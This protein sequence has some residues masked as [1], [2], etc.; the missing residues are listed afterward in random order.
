MFNSV[1]PAFKKLSIV[2]ILLFSTDSFGQVASL[3]ATFSLNEIEGINVPYQNG[4][5]VPSFEKQNRTIINL[6]GEWK[7]QRFNA[8]DNITLAK[9]DAAGYQNLINEAAERYLPSYDDSGWETKILPAVENEMHTYPTVP[10]YY[11]DGVWYRKDFNVDAADANNFIKLMF[12]S[13]NYVADVWINGNY[14]GYHEGGYTP[15]AFDVSPFLNYGG[16]NL[17]AVRVDNPGWGNR[18]DIVPYT[19]CD[20]FNY[21]GIIH[22]VYLEITDR[23]S[24]I[25]ANI[26]SQSIS[27]DVQTTLIIS[28]NNNADK[29]VTLNMQVYEADIN[30]N[31]INSES[32]SEILG[33]FISVSGITSASLV[34]SAD[35][36]EVWQTNLT[37]SDPKLWS[38]K[39]PNL[40]VMKISL[41]VNSVVVDEY[42]TQFGIRKL[43]L[44]G[45]KVRLNDKVIFLPGVARHE[46]HPIL[47]RSIPIDTIYSDLQK[48]KNINSVSLRTAHYPNHLQTYLLADRMGIAIIEEIPVWQF[49]NTAAWEIQNNIRH[50]HEQMF[51]EM[52]FKD[53]N[54]PS[55]FLW[56][57]VNECLD[58]PN[59]KIFIEKVN[60]D[61][62]QNY[63]DGRFIVQSAA[64]DRP[65]PEDDSQ[66]VCDVLGWT[67]YFGIFYGDSYFADTFNFINDAK[68]F[69]PDKP[70]LD[71]EFGFWSSENGSTTQEQVDVFTLTFPAFQ[72]HAALSANGN[73]N[74]N[75][76]LLGCTWWCIFDWYSNGHPFGYQ[77]MGLYDMFRNTLKPVGN[78]LKSAYS[79]YFQNGGTAT[80]IN[81]LQI[82]VPEKFSLEQNYPN[83]FNPI[84]VIRYTIPTTPLSFGEGLGVRLKVFDVLGSEVATLV[85]E[86]QQPGTYEVEFNVGQAISLSSGVYYYQLR[87]G[88]LIET[89]KMILLK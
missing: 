38:M 65:G 8:D 18:N 40:Y 58:V 87:A 75:G 79:P 29:D 23:V 2:I 34:I 54:R 31:N 48:V 28:N 52:V 11:E 72:I 7:K 56:S 12:Y 42:Y 15:F 68:S 60:Q 3:E 64:A 25:R 89:K 24:V 71:T 81:D 44:D 47:G 9:R 57:T 59:R 6:Q 10:E 43:L 78:V 86:P 77:S 45:D 33:S 80:G 63:P 1:I 70:I 53:F 21:T 76:A 13:V 35:S 49:D 50:I 62:K 20:W 83:P 37:V 22:D 73:I 30:E 17:I 46:D 85:N 88:D 67:M 41:S 16:S 32:A 5:P 36:F 69:F 74:E 26:V 84:T 51:R 14:L 82:E 39:A 55:I 19:D 4:M 61:L 27:G 66:N